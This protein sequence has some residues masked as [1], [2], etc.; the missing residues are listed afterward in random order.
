MQE[1]ARNTRNKTSHWDQDSRLRDR[2]VAFVSG[3]FV[4]PLAELELSGKP[5]PSL[6]ET[7]AAPRVDTGDFPDSNRSPAS[8]ITRTISF[9]L[10]E[11]SDGNTQPLHETFDAQS[12]SSD[13]VILFKGRDGLKAKN[14]A[15]TA[16]PSIASVPTFTS[17]STRADAQ[18]PYSTLLRPHEPSRLD[19]LIAGPDNESESDAAIQDYIANMDPDD[20]LDMIGQLSTNCRDLGGLHND[21]VITT[22]RD[23]KN[24]NSDRSEEVDDKLNKP[25]SSSESDNGVPDT[26]T[27]DSDG[28]EGEGEEDGDE[29][30]EDSSWK[31]AS[32]IDDEQLARLLAK[33]EELGLGVDELVLFDGDSL[34]PTDADEGRWNQPKKPGKPKGHGSWKQKMPA[35]YDFTKG[36]RT[37]DG[38]FPNAEAVADAFE[39]L[40]V[41]TKKHGRYAREL[42]LSDVELEATLKA[43]WQKDRLRKKERKKA[44]EELRAQGLLG[45]KVNALDPRVKYPNGMN[46]EDM[47]DEFHSFLLGSEHR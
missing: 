26:G 43:S 44:R 25:T 20:M 6:V 45:K 14:C 1:V 10:Q 19:M 35:G 16:M 42:E 24:D 34:G 17:S 9:S 12:D 23:S 8:P 37:S 39:Q 21:I 47:K 38:S 30:D 31:L 33:Q 18:I 3:G 22:T 15:L 27:E 28:G 29:D 5:T 2:P 41:T 13:E 46:L 11:A 40:Q 36:L 7:N 32:Q 4:E